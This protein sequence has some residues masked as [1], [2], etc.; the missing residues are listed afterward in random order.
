MARERPRAVS[1][2]AAKLG[3]FL[4]FA[5]Y[6]ANLAVSRAYKPLLDELGL[7][8]PQY[9]VLAALYDEDG[10]TVG[11]LGDKL[12]LDSS[13]LTPLLKRMERAGFLTRKRDLQDERQVRI[14]L[15]QRGRSAREKGFGFLDG[16]VEATGL[17]PGAYRQLLETMVKLRENLSPAPRR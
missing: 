2:N 4:C 11:G 5:I 13:T 17:P 12:F 7:T 10:Q 16:L 15:T 1:G 14:R 9:L 6:S 8:Y 3:E